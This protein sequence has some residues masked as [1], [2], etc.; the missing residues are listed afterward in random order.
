V[1][2]A[3]TDGTL[4][5]V[6][7]R[8]STHDGLVPGER[9]AVELAHVPALARPGF[10]GGQLFATAARSMGRPALNRWT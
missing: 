10:R 4:V 8:G 2:V 5:L 9:V 7:L 1:T 3:L 6:Q